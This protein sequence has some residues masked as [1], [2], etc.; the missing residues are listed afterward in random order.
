MSVLVNDST[1]NQCSG[2]LYV[3]RPLFRYEFKTRGFLRSFLERFGSFNPHL[4]PPPVRPLP[5]T[6]NN[7]PGHLDSASC[8]AHG[9]KQKHTRSHFLLVIKHMVLWCS[10]L[11]LLSN[12]QAVPGSNPGGI[13]SF[14]IFAVFLKLLEVRYECCK[15]G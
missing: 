4:S 12:T 1:A 15:D 5:D 11:S 10:W 8:P 3:C 6:D 2:G 7:L 13:I 14:A 9:R